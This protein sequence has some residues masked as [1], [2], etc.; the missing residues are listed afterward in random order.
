MTSALNTY[1]VTF[2]CAREI[3]EPRVFAG[4]LL[5]A[6]PS[7]QT[8]DVIILSLQEIASIGYSFV[9]G[10]CLTAYLEAFRHA[11]DIATSTV[12]NEKY[13]NII[14]RN[15]GM[16][17]I[18]AFVLTDQV[19]NVQWL[20]SAG[21]GLGVHEMGNKGAVGLRLGYSCGEEVIELAA[22]AAHLAPMEN[23]LDRRN[24]DWINIV[25]RLVF[26][27]EKK[28]TTLAAER[29]VGS[30]SRN[31]EN[32]SLLSRYP[33]KSTSSGS[34]IYTSTSH[35]I[36]AGDLNYRTSRSK[37]SP[38]DYQSY[39]QPTV[40]VTDPRHYSNLLRDDQL[41]RELKAGRTCHGLTEATIQFSP[42]YKYSNNQQAVIETNDGLRWDWAIHRFPSWCDR[43]LYLD[44]PSRMKEQDPSASVGVNG[45][46]SLPL[47]VT[48]DHRPV[49]LSL[50]LPARA[51]PAP[52]EVR[53]NGDMRVNPPF[54]LDAAW[55][56]K[57]KLARRKEITVGLLAILGLTWEGR[58][59]LLAMMLGAFGGWF[60]IM[61]MLKT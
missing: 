19:S 12:L 44:L 34:G 37:P 46:T 43:I 48:S 21:V 7:S 28:E 30:D 26:T 38:A 55:R 51:I 15:V 10:S 20:E 32:E 60:I 1:I 16:T 17:V 40:D 24:E 49:A 4:H 57:R 47:M 31:G 22:V 9:G 41:S 27:S 25:R 2:N 50:S 56:Q 18:M 8:P 42:T 39:P 29:I 35:L 33:G 52:T 23:G 53:T 6:L 36:L 3:V 13:T 14:T 59:L 58:M 54:A 45:Y 61:S 5:D 11:V